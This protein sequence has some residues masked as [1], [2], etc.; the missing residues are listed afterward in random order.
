[1]ESPQPS[2]RHWTVELG[3]RR[4]VWASGPVNSARTEFARE[5]QL[6]ARRVRAHSYTTTQNQSSKFVTMTLRLILGAVT[7]QRDAA[8]AREFLDETQRE[9]LAM[10]LDGSAARVDGAG[11]E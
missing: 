1:M 9:L 5:V 7:H 2:A 3:A 8:G 6:A 11:Q 10:I 4:V